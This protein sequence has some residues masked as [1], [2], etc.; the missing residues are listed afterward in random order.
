VYPVLAER[1][2]LIAWP[3]DHRY[4]SVGSVARLPVTEVFFARQPTVLFD[5]DGVLNR[6]PP[7]AE[8]VRRWEEFHWLPG[9]LE[10][11]RLLHEAGYRVI[12]VTNQ[13]GVGRG[14]M[15]EDSLAEVHS[16]MVADAEAAGGSIEAVYYCPHGWDDGCD[17]RKPAPG[18]LY[19][20]QRDFSLDLTRTVMFGDEDRDA[21]AAAAA[22]CQPIMVGPHKSLLAAIREF[23]RTASHHHPSAVASDA[24]HQVSVHG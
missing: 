4:Y 1:G 5:R 24:A 17:C 19:Q 11:L 6:R 22:G 23:L 9:T 2:Q 16:R 3:T 10:G 8:Y 15:T 20:A 14:L 12:V 21:E 13:A 7:R 18:L